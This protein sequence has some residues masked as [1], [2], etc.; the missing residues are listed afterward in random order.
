MQKLSELYKNMGVIFGYTCS[1]CGKPFTFTHSY[2]DGMHHVGLVHRCTEARRD[3][4]MNL[5]PT[6]E[7]EDDLTEA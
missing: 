3:I 2:H 1:H 7:L 6:A 4:D 5:A